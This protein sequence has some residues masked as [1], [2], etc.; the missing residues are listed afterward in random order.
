MSRAAS[1][2]RPC[3]IR[4]KV[5]CRVSMQDSKSASSGFL[6]QSSARSSHAGTARARSSSVSPSSPLSCAFLPEN[7]SSQP[8]SASAAAS[9]SIS[10]SL[11]SSNRSK[12][13]RKISSDGS[14][15]PDSI[16]DRYDTVQIP[17]QSPA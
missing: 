14:A 11:F 9:R 2:L 1:A 8:R 5:S 4:C 17:L 6:V 16:L 12:R 7:K 15:L 3:K 13:S 10:G